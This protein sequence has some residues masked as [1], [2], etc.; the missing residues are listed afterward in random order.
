MH[1]A[2][3][4]SMHSGRG[5]TTIATTALAAGTTA[6]KAFNKVS[7]G[8]MGV[9]HKRNGTHHTKGSKKDQPYG[10]KGPGIY[11]VVPFLH[12]YKTIHIRDRTSNLAEI[13]FNCNDQQLKLNASVI[14][15][16]MGYLRL[17]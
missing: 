8:E 17:L 6:F 5:I 12:S 14:L 13:Q 3:E 4:T 2:V 9:R 7:M 10:I 16:A 15:L 11:P 1:S